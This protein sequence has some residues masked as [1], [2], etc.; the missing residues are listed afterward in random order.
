METWYER[1]RRR[2]EAL[3]LKQA[4]I[5]RALGVSNATASDWEAGNTCPRGDNLTRLCRY[6]AVTPDWLLY[7]KGYPDSAAPSIAIPPPWAAVIAWDTFDDLP[8]GAYV[9]VPHYDVEISAGDGCQWVDHVENEPLAFPAHWFKA[10]G[11]KPQNCRAIYVRGDSMAPTLNDNDTVMIDITRTQVRDDAIF[12]LVYHDEL[13]IKRLF[14]L[15]GGGIE[16]RSDNPRHPNRVVTGSELE[17]VHVLGEMI[18]RA[19]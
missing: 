3:G 13:Y 18:W 15:P 6:L 10:K 8:S 9:A 1:L 5:K 19:G 14:R 16:L 2:R 4:D 12:A 17:A 7:G 11:T